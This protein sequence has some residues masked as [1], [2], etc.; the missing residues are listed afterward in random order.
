MVVEINGV[1]LH[2]ETAGAGEPLLWLHGFMGAGADWNVHL[3]GPAGWLL[4]DC[5]GS[6]RTRRVELS[7]RPVLISSERA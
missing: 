1:S 3:R 4:C 5:A 2:Y 7:T 6:P